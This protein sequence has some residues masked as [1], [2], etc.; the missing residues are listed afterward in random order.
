[1]SGLER[2]ARR[3]YM[4][5]QDLYQP[6]LDTNRLE[7]FR[8]VDWSQRYGQAFVELLEHLPTDRLS[9]KVAAT[10]VVTVEHDRLKA[11]L[12]GGQLSPRSKFRARLTSDRER[13]NE[14]F[15]SFLVVCWIA[16]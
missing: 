16:T 15:R 10:V 5:V 9:G 2:E 14:W 1:M 7:A 13:W 11:Q 8:P 6:P 12:G 3:E 4:T